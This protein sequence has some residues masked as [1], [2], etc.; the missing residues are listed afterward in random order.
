M[1][2]GSRTK[3]RK[4]IFFF[5]VIFALLLASVSVVNSSR[6]GA[7]ATLMLQGS[8]NWIRPNMS[9]RYNARTIDSG[10]PYIF[11]DGRKTFQ[12]GTQPGID[13]S[14]IVSPCSSG[15]GAGK[16][17]TRG[18]YNCP[19]AFSSGGAVA[20]TGNAGGTSTSFNW[21][22]WAGSGTAAAA[23]SVQGSWKV[24]TANPS[25]TATY[26]SQWIGIGGYSASDTTLIQVGTESDYYDGSAQYV[27]WYELIP[28][29]EV[30]INGFDISQ[31]DVI[32]ANIIK[33]TG[34]GAWTITL[35]D[36][37]TNQ[38]FTTTVTYS[39]S[40]LSSE[41][42]DE[43]PDICS[44]TCTEAPLT[45]FGKAYF[46]S[47]YT[48]VAGTDYANMGTSQPISG[49]PGLY[50][51]TLIGDG[52]G[53]VLEQPSTLSSD[54]TSFSISESAPTSTTTTVSTSTIPTTTIMPTSTTSVTT[55]TST[56]TTRSTTS[57]RPT[58]STAST[59]ST[60]STKQTTSTASTSTR[61]TTSTVST[62]STKSTTVPTT[63][64]TLATTSTVA[65]TASTTTIH[66][67]VLVQSACATSAVSGTNTIA[68]ASPVK[69]GD[70][71]VAAAAAGTYGGSSISAVS[72]SQGNSWSAGEVAY[73]AGDYGF[74]IIF[75]TSAK[76]A[77][78]DSVSVNFNNYI[79]N[80]LCIYE[81][82]GISSLSEAKSTS[83]SSTSTSVASVPYQSGALLLGAVG[84]FESGTATGT[85]GFTVDQ[86]LGGYSL[87][88][89]RTTAS[90]GSSTFPVTWT[91]G[92]YEQYTESVMVFNPS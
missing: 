28:A 83:T 69:K 70:L 76:S 43:R 15:H 20:Q 47:D 21:A 62:T 88:E 63:T 65:T 78:A 66:Q 73:A 45:N 25:N 30:P 81:L 16:Q 37:T 80:G 87:I 64:S 22:G 5:A 19:H 58:T 92:Y 68:F 17:Y 61:P 2:N 54:G 27:A 57:T 11:S 36:I 29:G 77:G 85:S 71:I 48:G 67:V 75:G 18:I 9:D 14:T 50:S 23:N 40:Q 41:W 53:G 49:I 56:R 12:L 7:P 13:F 60:T 46:G 91:E 26:S 52:G 59:R 34:P 79:R 90:S 74:S 8:G 55:S 33:G 24:Q 39:S 42:I 10:T 31:G 84:S 35:T 51:I 1:V 44:T 32:S 3:N 72:D 89:H 86:N 6:G 38:A 82:S 4:G